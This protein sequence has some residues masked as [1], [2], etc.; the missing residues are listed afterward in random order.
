M[1]LHLPAH[2]CCDDDAPGRAAAVG[3]G[4][5][6]GFAAPAAKPNGV[7]EEKQEVQNQTGKRQPPQQQDGLKERGAQF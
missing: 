2:E 7:E 3:V 4:L 5:F 6:R 1:C